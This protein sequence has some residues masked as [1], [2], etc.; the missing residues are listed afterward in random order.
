[1]L[2]RLLVSLCL[3][4]APLLAADYTGPRPPKPDIPYIL[5]ADHLIETES[6]QARQDNKKGEMTYT[7]EGATSPAR[8]PLTEPIFILDE[9]QLDPNRIE[10]YRLDS[11]NG[12]REITLT[13]NGRR[14]GKGGNRPLHLLVTPLGGHLYRIE[15]DEHLDDGEYSLSPPDSNTVFCF[16][17]Y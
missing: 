14:R 10:L 15:A 8:T 5:H 1:M 11:R 6:Q 7:I 9:Q 12:H 16:E 3:A 2:P 4:G 17:V 13:G